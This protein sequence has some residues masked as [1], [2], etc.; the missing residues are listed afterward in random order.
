[1]ED[2]ERINVGEVE[3]GLQECKE[4]CLAVP[5]CRS[6]GY[7]DRM[8]DLKKVSHGSRSMYQLVNIEKM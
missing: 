2:T 5:Q 6:I 8:F 4:A 7:V 1:M 3:G